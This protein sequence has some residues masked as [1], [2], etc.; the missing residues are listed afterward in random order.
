[1]RTI[2]GMHAMRKE[3][4]LKLMICT[5]FFCVFANDVSVSG[6]LHEFCWFGKCYSYTTRVV[7]CGLWQI[8]H[9]KTNGSVLLEWCI[10]FDWGTVFPFF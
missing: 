1:M 6:L 5:G 7:L 10:K 4:L 3:K 2:Q 9:S 8:P